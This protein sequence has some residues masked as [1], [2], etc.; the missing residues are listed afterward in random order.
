MRCQRKPRTPSATPYT[1]TAPRSHAQ[2]PA[3]SG[4]CGVSCL[5]IHH[6]TAASETTDTRRL[7]RRWVCGLMC[8]MSAAFE[9]AV[10]TAADLAVHRALRRVR[11]R[12]LHRGRGRAPV[13]APA[14]VVLEEHVEHDEQVAAAHLVE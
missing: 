1:Q 2:P 6:A 3:E 13:V 5:E 4:N 7:R 9:A 12:A 14:Q 10:Q 8:G 11:R